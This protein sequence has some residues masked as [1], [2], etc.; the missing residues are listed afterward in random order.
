MINSI[1]DIVSVI[2]IILID[3]TDHIHPLSW[4]IEGWCLSNM[5]SV[6][7]VVIKQWNKE[8]N[9]RLVLFVSCPK[10]WM[11]VVPQEGRSIYG[12]LPENAMQNVITQI[13]NNASWPS[14]IFKRD[15]DSWRR[16]RDPAMTGSAMC[17]ADK[18][19][20]RIDSNCELEV[21]HYYC[22]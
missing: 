2:Q 16:L 14:L 1:V 9:L 18:R 6:Q 4:R 15:M 11:H 8:I 17:N 22:R 10:Y 21:V 19:L 12:T 20:K 13:E 5:C 3:N 7:C